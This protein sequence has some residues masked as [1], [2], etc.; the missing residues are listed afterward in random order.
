VNVCEDGEGDSPV[1]EV[2]EGFNSVE[3]LSW[4]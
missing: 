1:G 3:T 2:R 4:L